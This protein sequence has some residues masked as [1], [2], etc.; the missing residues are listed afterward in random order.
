MRVWQDEFSSED[1]TGAAGGALTVLLLIGIS[2]GLTWWGFPAEWGT[3]SLENRI[4]VGI[5]AFVAFFLLVILCLILGSLFGGLGV[6]RI[7]L[8]ME[9]D[10]T[11][12]KWRLEFDT[13]ASIGKVEA[14]FKVTQEFLQCRLVKRESEKSRKRDLHDPRRYTIVED[15]NGQSPRMLLDRQ[16]CKV[17]LPSSKVLEG[18]VD[19]DKAL[20]HPRHVTAWIPGKGQP[21]RETVLESFEEDDAAGRAAFEYASRSLGAGDRRPGED[22]VIAVR[23]KVRWQVDLWAERRGWPDTGVILRLGDASEG[24]VT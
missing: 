13:K 9:A 14:R 10:G 1:K 18:I 12:L 17:L 19:L 7:T 3:A 8:R 2:G 21:S 20:P 15:W 5:G 4:W 22:E 24:D 6:R 11:R 23:H 16:L